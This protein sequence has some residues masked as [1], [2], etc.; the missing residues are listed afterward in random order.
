[1]FDN[2]ARELLGYRTLHHVDRT[3]WINT[4]RAFPRGPLRRDQQL[5][6]QLGAA[7]NIKQD[8]QF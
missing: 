3:V 1:M 4:A 2:W 5:F 6:L 7:W 8:G